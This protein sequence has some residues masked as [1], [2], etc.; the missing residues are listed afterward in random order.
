M[1]THIRCVYIYKKICIYIYVYIY[2]YS[3]MSRSLMP[4]C[5]VRGDVVMY[6]LKRGG[7]YG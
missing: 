2:T 6:I 1:Y 7:G 4:R 5:S 3:T